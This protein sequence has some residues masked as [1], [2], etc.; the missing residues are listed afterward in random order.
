MSMFDFSMSE[1][2]S[3]PP[4]PH[5]GVVSS[6]FWIFWA[7]T[8]PLTLTVLVIWR[9]CMRRT[10]RPE[11]VDDSTLEEI[12]EC[13]NGMSCNDPLYPETED[14]FSMGSGQLFGTGEEKDEDEC[15]GSSAEL[16]GSNAI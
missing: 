6:N 14:F 10:H 2:P 4:R 8:V 1:S 13:S 5:S 9:V 3:V 15:E 12:A 16:K 7:V 11:T